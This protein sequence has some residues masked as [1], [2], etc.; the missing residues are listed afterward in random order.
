MIL[1]NMCLCI[2]VGKTNV[3]LYGLVYRVACVEVNK[4]GEDVWVSLNLLP[5]RTGSLF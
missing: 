5:T 4:R 1:V 2:S 3:K